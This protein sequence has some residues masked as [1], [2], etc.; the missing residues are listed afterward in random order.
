MLVVAVVLVWRLNPP[1]AS[2]FVVFESS[3]VD[4]TAPESGLMGM[5][6]P[7]V[8]GVEVANTMPDTSTK[9]PVVTDLCTVATGPTDVPLAT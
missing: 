9:L 2:V 4:T 1:E 8:R 6:G 7:D 5:D 3:D